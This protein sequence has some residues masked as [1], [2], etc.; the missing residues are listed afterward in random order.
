MTKI[1]WMRDLSS[2][3]IG[4][5]ISESSRSLGFCDMLMHDC[6]VILFCSAHRV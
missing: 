4:L 3:A 2:G 1:D 6:P 5:P